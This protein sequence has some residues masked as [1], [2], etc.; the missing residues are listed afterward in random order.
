[1]E[2]QIYYSPLTFT[3]PANFFGKFLKK[4]LGTIENNFKWNIYATINVGPSEIQ[5]GG[6]LAPVPLLSILKEINLL[7]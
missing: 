6:T 2:Q 1:M 7:I 5:F 4:S 3:R